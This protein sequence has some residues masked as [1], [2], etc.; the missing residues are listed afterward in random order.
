MWYTC[1]EL[2]KCYLYLAQTFDPSKVVAVVGSQS[3]SVTLSALNILTQLRLPTI[4]YS[5]TSADLDDRVNFPYFSRTVPSDSVQAL[6]LVE[7]LRFL[8]VSYVGFLYQNNNYGIRGMQQFMKQAEEKGICVES[9]IAVDA[10]DS[11]STIRRKLTS[12]L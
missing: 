12:I 10:D 11:S 7:I 1:T 9:P 4:S 6:V 5:A 3:S 8:N 2:N